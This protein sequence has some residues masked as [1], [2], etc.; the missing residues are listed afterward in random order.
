MIRWMQLR[1]LASFQTDAPASGPPFKGG[2]IG[3]ISYDFGRVFETIPTIAPDDLSL[4]LFEFQYHDRVWTVDR[5]TDD[6]F[7]ITASGLVKSKP[8]KLGSINLG[9]PA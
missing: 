6:S 7:R 2:W 5:S 3:W 8:M 4:P 1:W 9:E